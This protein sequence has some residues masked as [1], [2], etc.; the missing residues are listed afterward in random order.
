MKHIK[1]LKKLTRW[2][3][4]RGFTRESSELS[5]IY[6]SAISKAS[7]SGLKDWLAGTTDSK[8]SFNDLFE[9][10]LRIVIPFNT[11][12][13]RALIKIISLLRDEGWMPAGKGGYFETKKV[14]QKMRHLGGE[15][16]SKEVEVA[17]LK[18]VEEITKTIPAGPRVGEE[19]VQRKVLSLA[20][21]LGGKV[22]EGQLEWWLKIQT[23]YVKDY[24]WKQLEAIFHKQTDLEGFS[25]V[26]SR[27]PIDVLRMSDHEGIESCHSEGNSYFECAVAES[28]GQGLIAYLVDSKELNKLLQ[29]ESPW[30]FDQDVAD[31]IPDPVTIDSF[32]GK[33]IFEDK[34]RGVS[35]IKPKSRVR[36]RK[37]VYNEGEYEFAAPENRTYGPHPPG[38][39]GAVRE[40]AWESQKFL[41]PQQTLF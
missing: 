24:N 18:V 11:K 7:I 22:S 35:G 12:E 39:V 40:W 10:N 4:S 23:E 17:D 14:N 2:L 33:E 25:I 6:K 41:W 9:E 38:F 26:V 37:Y 19:V 32:D 13:K 34:Q 31:M 16:Y 5:H 28:R 21:A 30:G 3:R 29:P 36:L 20:K 8:L 15:E 1:K 27:D